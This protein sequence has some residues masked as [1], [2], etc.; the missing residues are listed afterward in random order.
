MSESNLLALQGATQ[1]SRFD[2][3]FPGGVG[4]QGTV[5]YICCIWFPLV[6]PLEKLYH[7]QLVIFVH[8]AHFL[9]CSIVFL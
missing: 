4:S 1:Y 9:F 8:G 5:N 3:K 7:K 6:M 2:E